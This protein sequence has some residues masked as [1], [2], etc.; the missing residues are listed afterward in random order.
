[1]LERVLERVGPAALSLRPER[2]DRLE[3]V[4]ALEPRDLLEPEPPVPAHRLDAPQ[5][6]RIRPALHRR[7]RHVPHAGEL[8]RRKELLHRS[9]TPLN[10]ETQLLSDFRYTARLGVRSSRVAA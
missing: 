4:R 2:P 1:A 3:P 7:L 8:G 6:A 10:W 9:S 5:L